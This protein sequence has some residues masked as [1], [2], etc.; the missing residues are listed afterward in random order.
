MCLQSS[1][2]KAWQK[3]MTSL[4]DLPL[5]SK[6]QPPLPPPIGSVVR[7]FFKICMNGTRHSSLVLHQHLYIL[8]HLSLTFL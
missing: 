1:V 7:L 2:M 8:P 5:G 6:S 3:R 4:S